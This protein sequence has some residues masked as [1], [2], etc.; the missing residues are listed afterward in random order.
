[1]EA[2]R[3]LYEAGGGKPVTT[4]TFTPGEKS[5]I[6]L[7][8]RLQDAALSAVVIGALQADAAVI[9]TEVRARGLAAE[10]IG[11]EALGL[12][13]FQALAGPAGEGVVFTA[14]EDAR[15]LPGAA[16]LTETLRA[17]GAEPGS[18]TIFAF[19]AVEAYAAAAASGAD[20]EAV[21]AR[22]RSAEVPTVIGPVRF[23]DKGDR[24]GARWR[25][26][27]WQAGAPRPLP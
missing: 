3:K 16:A 5:Q 18:A 10:L 15:L 7:A 24:I 13:E 25:L 4:E 14:P 21:T 8:G 2:V 1:M 19:A 17:A 9:A 22:L 12:A 11:T 27:T 26:M 20:F 6:T 23:D